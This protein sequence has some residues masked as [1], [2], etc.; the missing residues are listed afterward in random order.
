MPPMIPIRAEAIRQPVVLR[1]RMPCVT[2]QTRAPTPAT[3]CAYASVLK[4]DD[5]QDTSKK[6][7]G[8]MARVMPKRIPVAHSSLLGGVGGGGTYAFVR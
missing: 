8:M 4:V 2:P 3:N 7:I 5:P 6:L 1:L